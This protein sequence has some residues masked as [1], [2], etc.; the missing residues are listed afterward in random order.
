ML[1]G[2]GEPLCIAEGASEDEIVAARAHCLE[3]LCIGCTHEL[4]LLHESPVPGSSIVAARS[5]CAGSLAC[6]VRSPSTIL[7]MQ[8][9]CSLAPLE[10]TLRLALPVQYTAFSPPLDATRLFDASADEAALAWALDGQTACFRRAS[11]YSSE[12]SPPQAGTTISFNMQ[13]SDCWRPASTLGN[14]SPLDGRLELL[15]LSLLPERKAAL[16]A[17][18]PRYGLRLCYVLL[19][20]EQDLV[21]YLCEHTFE[22]KWHPG[23]ETL[24]AFGR[25]A[26][27]L[28]YHEG[29]IVADEHYAVSVR[30]PQLQ[31]IAV[32]IRGSSALCS[33]RDGYVWELL[34]NDSTE[35]VQVYD[36]IAFADLA[37]S[38]VCAMSLPLISFD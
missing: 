32:D 25:N 1:E 16:L 14:S 35:H 28:L 7:L 13:P 18:C 21:E 2:G 17:N 30:L 19:Q 11:L 29:I 6:L 5:P 26:V 3:V 8:Q 31:P 34:L 15:A 38:P 4:G 33:S 23:G 37:S 20:W 12:T 27:V 22:D 9:K 10:P 36:K 24:R